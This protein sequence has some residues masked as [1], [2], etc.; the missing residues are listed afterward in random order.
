MAGPRADGAD[1]L[2][3]AEGGTAAGGLLLPTEKTGG[4]GL[5]HPGPTATTGVEMAT[6]FDTPRTRRALPWRLPSLR[7]GAPIRPLALPRRF[8]VSRRLIGC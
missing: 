7:P 6:V 5:F 2:A 3:G 4:N 8:A 1:R